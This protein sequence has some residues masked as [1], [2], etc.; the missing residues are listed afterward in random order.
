MRGEKGAR[1]GLGLRGAAKLDQGLYGDCLALLCKHA[2]GE[3]PGVLVRERE[4]ALRVI[5]NGL[6][7]S[8]QQREFVRG[9]AFGGVCLS[10][11]GDRRAVNCVAP[12]IVGM[13]DAWRAWDGR[14]KRA[15]L[16]RRCWIGVRWRLGRRDGQ[17]GAYAV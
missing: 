6:A 2:R 11:R 1:T 13:G 3:K 14:C 16:G 17:E 10:L 15:V 9:G 4:R 7:G 12:P 5:G 8:S